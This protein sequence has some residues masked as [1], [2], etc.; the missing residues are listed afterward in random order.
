MVARKKK[1]N[2]FTPSLEPLVATRA[3][4]LDRLAHYDNR[5]T[6]RGDLPPEKRTDLAT[7]RALEGMGFKIV[8]SCGLCAE[9]Q[10][11][12]IPACPNVATVEMK[13]TKGGVVGFMDGPTRI[14]YPHSRGRK[15]Y[16]PRREKGR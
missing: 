12:S 10:G 6:M 1:D 16:A 13:I 8:Y 9:P 4:L 5:D 14:C 7:L 3:D 2:G 15:V 11:R